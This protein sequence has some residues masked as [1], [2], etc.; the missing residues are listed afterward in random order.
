MTRIP[1]DAVSLAWQ[2]ESLL[3]LEKKQDNL[4]LLIFSE[5][6]DPKRKVSTFNGERGFILSAEESRV[7]LSIDSN[8]VLLQGGSQKIVAKASSPS[9][10]FWH[11]ATI[12]SD[13]YVQEYGKSPTGIW[14]VK[15]EAKR[16]VTNLDLDIHSKHFHYIAKD[17]RRDRLVVTLGDGNLV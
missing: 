3:V 10:F 17:S 5:D 2:G 11:A 9:N 4:D 7:L 14:L 12:K 13:L 1:I 6:G 16:L 8:L 15:D